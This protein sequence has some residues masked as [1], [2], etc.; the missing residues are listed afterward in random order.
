MGDITV[1]FALDMAEADEQQMYVACC[2]DL[3]DQIWSRASSLMQDMLQQPSFSSASALVECNSG[4]LSDPQ[5]NKDLERIR[6]QLQSCKTFDVH[7]YFRVA[8]VTEGPFADLFGVGVGTNN[9]KLERAS[10]LALTVAAA[11]QRPDCGDW[12]ASQA[13]RVEED[14]F[15]F[16]RAT[17]A[18]NGGAPQRVRPCRTVE[19]PTSQRQEARSRSPQRRPIRRHAQPQSVHGRGRGVEG[20]RRPQGAQPRLA[21]PVP[22]WSRAALRAPEKLLED[23]DDDEEG[24][25]REEELKAEHVFGDLEEV[26]AKMDRQEEGMN[27]VKQEL[28]DDFEEGLPDED[29][30]GS[31]PFCMRPP[32]PWVWTNHSDVN[33][34]LISGRRG[35]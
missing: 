19:A 33:D 7:G 26:Q 11:V 4:S 28:N 10:R 14:T 24:E 20:S 34:V 9:K 2:E 8:W 13:I 17:D 23:D 12:L 35:L 32:R 18:P 15:S 3:R 6:E 21:Q 31:D 27:D 29:Q 25:V 5:E 22:P 16:A 1:V 30:G